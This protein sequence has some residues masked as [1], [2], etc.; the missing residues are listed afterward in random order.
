M[1]NSRGQGQQLLVRCPSVSLF[2]MSLV[3]SR[4]QLWM[5]TRT[6][7]QNT[8]NARMRG[9][10]SSFVSARSAEGG[11]VWPGFFRSTASSLACVSKLFGQARGAQ[12]LLFQMGCGRLQT[13]VCCVLTRA[14]AETSPPVIEPHVGRL[15]SKTVEE[16]VV[17]H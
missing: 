13:Q 17:R 3:F 1:T 16:H 11:L 5:C 4:A 7:Q 15:T 14:P 2:T 6:H 12:D 10:A 8:W 9:A